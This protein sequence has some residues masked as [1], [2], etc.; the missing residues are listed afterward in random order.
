VAGKGVAAAL[1][2]AKISSDARFCMLTETDPARAVLKINTL[3]QEAGMLDRFVTLAACQLDPARHEVSFINAGHLPPLV[4]RKTT[5][6]LEEGM[7]REL[8]GLPLG[9][10][11]D[12][13]YEAHTVRLDPGD[14]V[15]LFTDGVTEAKN[16][17][18]R[19]FRVEGVQAAALR[20]GPFTPNAMAERVVNA[21]KQH[22]L[23]CKQYDD[24]TVACF[25][26]L[27]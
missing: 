25:G 11:E 7:P 5:G 20:Q 8:A 14:S 10:A 24:I 16:R 15:L 2:M 27:V 26:R 18:D 4:F 19:E 13:P 3:M 9:V 22:S 17:Q 12:V 23:G 6:K 1:L 21:V